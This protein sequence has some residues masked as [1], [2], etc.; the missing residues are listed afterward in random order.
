L[1]ISAFNLRII[2]PLSLALSS[3]QSSITR[4]ADKK[5]LR[6]WTWATAIVYLAWGGGAGSSHMRGNLIFSLK[7]TGG[8]K[9]SENNNANAKGMKTT[10][11]K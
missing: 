10:R 11:A 7:A 2:L 1:H 3:D 5:E 6:D 4:L 9:K 8:I